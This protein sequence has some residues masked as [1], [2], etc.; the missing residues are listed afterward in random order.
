[1]LHLPN[2]VL[3]QIE[4]PRPITPSTPIDGSE[5]RVSTPYTSK[6]MRRAIRKVKENPSKRNIDVLIRANISLPAQHEIDTKVKEG[7][8]RAFE[9][10]KEKRKKGW[11]LNLAGEPSTG[12]EV[13][14]PR[15]VVRAREYNAIQDEEKRIELE[16]KEAKKAANAAK[17]ERDE[18]DKKERAVQRE[19]ARQ[20]R[21][22]LAVEKKESRDK[23]LAER[24]AAKEAAIMAK[25]QLQMQEEENKKKH[26]VVKASKTTAL[27]PRNV[28]ADTEVSL[29]EEVTISTTN[30]G[31][32]VKLPRRFK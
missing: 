16:E 4:I 13:W 15:A 17:K 5:K 20:E 6:A 29:E 32:A 23:L 27:K 1:L 31:R 28:L 14:S 2:I 26:T 22:R 18:N 19:I 8:F 7:L 10:E 9:L 11:K 30:K 3:S 12:T 25:T 24:Q 21:E